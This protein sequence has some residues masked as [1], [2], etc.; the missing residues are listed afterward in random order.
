MHHGITWYHYFEGHQPNLSTELSNP[1][2]ALE[3]YRENA[4]KTA[5]HRLSEYNV[6]KY[7]GIK[8]ARFNQQKM[9]VF[10]LFG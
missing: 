9:M 1:G 6:L 8:C 5:F 10:R 7:T 2:L 3:T 4:G